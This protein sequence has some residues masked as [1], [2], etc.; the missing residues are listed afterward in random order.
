[1]VAYS[2]AAAGTAS[3]IVAAIAALA[4]RPV[5]IFIPL[6]IAT[7]LIPDKS[8]AADARQDR[9]PL[10]ANSG[11]RRVPVSSGHF[12]RCEGAKSHCCDASRPD[13]AMRALLPA[14]EYHESEFCADR[15]HLV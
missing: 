7:C 8:L 1:M 6:R 11:H 4:R 9:C 5:I 12:D 14:L 10:F 15:R 13:Y 2:A 3:T